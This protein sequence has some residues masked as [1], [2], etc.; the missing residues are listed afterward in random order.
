MSFFTDPIWGSIFL[1]A[2]DHTLRKDATKNS[3]S[4]DHKGYT[5]FFFI[6]DDKVRRRKVGWLAGG[7]LPIIAD[8]VNFWKSLKPASLAR[9]IATDEHF[10]WR[11][12]WEL[13]SKTNL[14]I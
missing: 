8:L 1:K 2:K 12:R 10:T 6:W 14:E 5:S 7:L 11:A 9:L 4:C 3:T 13:L